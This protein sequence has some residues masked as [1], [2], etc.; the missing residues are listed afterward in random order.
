MLSKG[1]AWARSGPAKFYMQYLP[2]NISCWRWTEKKFCE[3]HKY[4]KEK[5]GGERENITKSEAWPWAHSMYRH[6][7]IYRRTAT[8]AL[9][10]SRSLKAPVRAEYIL[11]LHKGYWQVSKSFGGRKSIFVNRWDQYRHQHNYFYHTIECDTV[12][13]V[14]RNQLHK[15]TNTTHSLYV[16]I[17]QIFVHSR[18]W[19]WFQP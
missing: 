12:C 6:A 14:H 11:Q 1:I 13:T 10:S 19:N 9:A 18:G 8:T 16:F 17:L 5:R 2:G 4:V 15:Q 3:A 7:I